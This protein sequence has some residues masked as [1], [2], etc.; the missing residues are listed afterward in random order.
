MI[1]VLDCADLC[2]IWNEINNV[3]INVCHCVLFCFITLLVHVNCWWQ[4]TETF[5]KNTTS[6]DPLT[7]WLSLKIASFSSIK[8]A[9]RV[10]VSI[11][12]QWKIQSDTWNNDVGLHLYTIYKQ[13]SQL[14]CRFRSYTVNPPTRLTRLHIQQT[15]GVLLWLQYGRH[16]LLSLFLQPWPFSWL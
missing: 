12:T 2:F 5:V 10:Q 11:C 8:Y 7:V 16:P 3:A 6:N 4:I 14:T 13:T 9:E 15:A 1:V